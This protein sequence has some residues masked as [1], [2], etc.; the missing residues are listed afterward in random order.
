M[1]KHP[2]D[3]RCRR[4]S[5][6]PIV[7]SP[8]SVAVRIAVA[9]LPIDQLVPNPKNPRQHSVRQVRQIAK[10]I[11]TFGFI[12]PIV[13]DAGRNVIIGH[14]RWQAAKQIGLTEVPTIQVEHLSRA[15]LVA[16]TIADNRLTET[17]SWD[18]RLL[19]E[20]LK[21][22]SE[23]DLDFDI[24]ST[25]FE[26]GEIDLRIESLES[27]GDSQDDPADTIPPMP[28]RPPVS[29]TGDLWLLGRHRLGCG[30]ALDRRAYGALMDG[31]RADLV[32]TDP[33]YNVP[34]DGHASGLGAIRHRDFVMAA[35][36]MGEEEFTAFLT[37]A[38]SL[39]AS[40]S[41][42]GAIHFLCMDWRHLRQL[43]AAGGEVYS[44][45]KNICV[46]VKHNAGMGSFYRSQHE[47]VCVFKH[48]RGAH[49]NNVQ[50]GQYGRHRT[51]VWSYPGVNSF[52]RGTEEGNLLALHPTVK[53]V[54]MVTDAILD[55]S[56]RGDIVLD[57]FMGSGTTVMAAERVGRRCYGMELDPLYVDTTI[58][59]WQAFTGATA[60]LSE[61]G[62]AFDEVVSGKETRNG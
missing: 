42:E 59:R 13:I 6:Q 14:G 24:E 20:Q 43:L 32:F 58:R 60:R 3:L 41:V 1:H 17:S 40:N 26:M 19:A 22:L 4:K 53:P 55:C 12:S 61:T 16:L 51:N 52:G 57:P 8:S 34:I 31:E 62:R 47:L 21:E 45:L 30:S 46:W 9:Y 39:L 54:A 50:L 38:C 56:A 10:S 48:G 15:Q 7:G 44:E 23:L 11:T 25:G 33:P 37:E 29:R 36:E 5:R 2:S 35:G 27:G 18:E 49:R 28:E